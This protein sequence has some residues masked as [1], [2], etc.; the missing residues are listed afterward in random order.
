MY[1]I[2]IQSGYKINLWLS[3]HVRVHTYSCG[4]CYSETSTS[5]ASERRPVSQSR[6]G[7]PSHVYVGTNQ[8]MSTW[9][10]RP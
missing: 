7:I 4:D 10:G 5:T 6:S 2:E 9:P 8:N 3:E 1:A